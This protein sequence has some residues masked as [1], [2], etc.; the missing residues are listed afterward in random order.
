MELDQINAL[1]DTAKAK[2]MALEKLYDQQGWKYVKEWAV[3]Q[4]N[5]QASRILSATSWE[6]H[7]LHK[8]AYDAFNLFVNLEN[9]SENEFSEIANS[10]IESK[11]EEVDRAAESDYE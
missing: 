4:A 10:I 8:G 9:T 6:Q 5:E 3:A 11:K 2:Y 7:C 1:P